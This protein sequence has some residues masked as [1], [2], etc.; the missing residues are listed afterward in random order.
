MSSFIGKLF[1]CGC[2]HESPVQKINLPPEEVWEKEV[3]QQIIK[4]N[5]TP[6]A[7]PTVPIDAVIIEDLSRVQKTP[8]PPAA[9][10]PNINNASIH[11]DADLIVPFEREAPKPVQN[12]LASPKIEAVKVFQ[13]IV[14]ENEQT[15]I[16][17]RAAT[18][19][20]RINRLTNRFAAKKKHSTPTRIYRSIFNGRTT[21]EAEQNLRMSPSLEQICKGTFLD[22]SE[23]DRF[24]YIVDLYEEQT[25][26][27]ND[28]LAGG[29][30]VGE[31]WVPFTQDGLKELHNRNSEI[32][33]EILRLKGISV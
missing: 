1:R 26:N 20:P 17:I 27:Y 32:R 24:K 25:K 16:P 9:I 29:K 30:T 2:V 3:V 7:D 5:S 22:Q 14:I 12:I 15:M 6:P 18:E 31:E 23:L 10:I 33:R 11:I 21:P 8:T 4:L 13:P 28:V 19:V